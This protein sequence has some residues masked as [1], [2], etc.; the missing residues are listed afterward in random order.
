MK[1]QSTLAPCGSEHSLDVFRSSVFSFLTALLPHCS[2][3]PGAC[4]STHP[5][6]H[7]NYMSAN[8]QIRF[9]APYEQKSKLPWHSLTSPQGVQFS[10][11]V[12]SSVKIPSFERKTLYGINKEDLFT[13]NIRYS[14][15]CWF[16]ALAAKQQ[17]V[18]GVSSE[19]YGTLIYTNKISVARGW[20]EPGP[21]WIALGPVTVTPSPHSFLRRP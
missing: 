6:P 10:S 1:Q 21:V 11:Q 2:L 7:C 19:T 9:L 8:K 5:A 14:D 13:R 12:T 17:G 18:E 3:P 4:A 15:A 16:S 20:G